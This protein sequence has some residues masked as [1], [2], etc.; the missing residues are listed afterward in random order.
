MGEMMVGGS[1][2]GSSGESMEVVEVEWVDERRVE[3]EVWEEVCR[4]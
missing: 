2:L 4:G 1:A 3:E